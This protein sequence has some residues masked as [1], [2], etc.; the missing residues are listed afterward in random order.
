MNLLGHTIGVCS[1]S[2]RATGTAEL[3][4]TVKGL[5]L[6]D[7]HLSVGRLLTTASAEERDRDLGL[8]RDSGLRL[9]ATQIGFHGEDYASIS[10][11]RRTGGFVPDE[12]WDDRREQTVA[13]AEL[14]AQLGAKYLT[15]HAGFIPAPNDAN[16]EAVV[17]RVTGLT[18]AIAEFGV[19]LLLETGQE[20]PSELLQFLNNVRSRH[21]G[22]NFDPANLLLYGS[23]DPVDAIQT[24]GRHIRHVHV[25]DAIKSRKPGVEW[26]KEVPFGDGEIAHAAFIDALHAAHYAGPLVIEREAGPDR[27]REIR[28]ALE[29]LEELTPA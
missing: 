17:E 22:V 18:A 12:T 29:T 24:L 10:S 8:L 7:V 3:I 15:V 21:L 5:G 28:F 4:E 2:L 27:I 20:S 23:G 1:W 9:T 25:K 26:G 19:E 13:A 16:Y 11:I 6:A 14:T